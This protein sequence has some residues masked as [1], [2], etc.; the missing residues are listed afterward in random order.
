MNMPVVIHLIVDKEDL[1]G[2]Y[3]SWWDVPVPECDSHGE[4][5]QKRSEYEKMKKK[6]VI[7]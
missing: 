5:N 4:P 7:R 2:G 1:T 6:Q 3:G